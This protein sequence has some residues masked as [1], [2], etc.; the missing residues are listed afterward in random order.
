MGTVILRPIDECN[1]KKIFHNHFV[2]IYANDNKIM[3]IYFS[4][5]MEMYEAI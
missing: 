1:N 5:I 3:K 2:L 4:Y